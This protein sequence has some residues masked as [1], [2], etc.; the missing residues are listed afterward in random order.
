M[1]TSLLTEKEDIINQ[2]LNLQS[3]ALIHGLPLLY[4]TSCNLLYQYWRNLLLTLIDLHYLK[5]FRKE[6]GLV[7]QG[8]VIQH[9]FARILGEDPAVSI[10]VHTPLL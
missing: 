7:P 1:I 2:F 10:D 4:S 9:Q 8:A 5:R 6:H 3:V